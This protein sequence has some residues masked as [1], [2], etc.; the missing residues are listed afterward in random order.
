MDK[1][2]AASGTSPRGY[3]SSGPD[4]SANIA[5]FSWYALGILPIFGSKPK[6][7]M[8]ELVTYGPVGGAGRNPCFYPEVDAE[9]RAT[10]FG[11]KWTVRCA[12]PLIVRLSSKL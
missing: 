6:N 8:T 1:F 11:D 3:S 9:N 2:P 12:H 7:R 5:T 10:Y 4:D